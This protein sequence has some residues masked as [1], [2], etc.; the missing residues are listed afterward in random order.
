M[1]GRR[2]VDQ[3]Q[4]DSGLLRAVQDVLHH[5]ADPEKPYDI[6]VQTLAAVLHRGTR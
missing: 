1:N 6:A 4:L 5:V 3:R 2:G